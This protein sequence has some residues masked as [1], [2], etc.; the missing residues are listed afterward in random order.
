MEMLFESSTF[1][2]NFVQ[3][4]LRSFSFAL[5]FSFPL[6]VVARTPL[7]FYDLF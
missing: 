5:F 6:G 2:M 1:H 7:E 4:P 3:R